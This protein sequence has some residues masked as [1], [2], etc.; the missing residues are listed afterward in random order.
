MATSIFFDALSLGGGT[1]QYRYWVSDYTFN[2][3]DG[4][5]IYFEYGLYENI[6]PVSDSTDWDEISWEPDPLLGAGAFDA[7]ALTDG[8]SLAQPFIVRFNWLGTGTPLDFIQNFE[9]YNLYPFQILE[10]GTTVP[11]PEPSIIS[12]LGLGIA[13]MGIFYRKIKKL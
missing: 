12:L 4:F 6:I 3:N 5:T 9:R 10:T 7:L 11:V 2:T 8:A 1:W 13:S